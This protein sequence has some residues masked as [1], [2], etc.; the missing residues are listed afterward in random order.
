MKRPSL[1]RVVAI[2]GG[3]GLPLV[4]RAL[5]DSAA[6]LTAIVTMA[7]DGGSSG[8]LREELGILPPGDVRNCLTA[9]AED[10]D[11][12]LV[13]LLQYRFP[14]GRTLAEH[15]LG[16]LVIAGMTDYEGGFV[17]ATRTLSGLLRCQG[18]VLPSTLADVNLF[19]DIGG[20]SYM[21]GQAR[22]AR[23]ERIRQVHLEPRD[24]PA[25]PPAVD[26]IQTADLIII[27]PGSL[28]TS[29]IPNLL[30]AGVA[31][32]M[33]VADCPKV[34]VLNTMNM[35]AETFGMT[36]TDYVEAL[37][38]HAPPAIIDS[39]LAHNGFLPESVPAPAGKTAHKVDYDR[40]T[41]SAKGL[42]VWEAD[43]AAPEQPFQ[44]DVG[45][46]SEV[47][48]QIIREETK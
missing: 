39:V 27:A 45:K 18:T 7:D 19:A 43:I 48:R 29:I 5:K 36:G 17:P 16:N 4:L 28:F 22:I 15:S 21:A 24:A 46:L 12:D 33:A 9:L 3:T 20:D 42:R 31:K 14:T 6:K 10:P 34:F 26:A 30:I 35:R 2:G 32:A 40:A 44:H 23:T 1:K 38:R 37:F 47:F 8:K 11:S 41:L 25:Y 13:H